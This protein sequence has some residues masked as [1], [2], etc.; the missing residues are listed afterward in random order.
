MIKIE[1]I[2]FFH[3]C[4]DTDIKVKFFGNITQRFTSSFPIFGHMAFND[5]SIT[6]FENNQTSLS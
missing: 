1:F 6:F 4:I 5:S 2:E 3:K